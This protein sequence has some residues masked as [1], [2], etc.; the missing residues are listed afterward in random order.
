MNWEKCWTC[1]MAELGWE[2][3]QYR[4]GEGAWQKD[5][6]QY[7]IKEQGFKEPEKNLHYFHYHHFLQQ[8]RSVYRPY[9]NSR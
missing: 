5:A 4:G 3:F 7:K 6:G 1:V 2:I 9:G 8:M